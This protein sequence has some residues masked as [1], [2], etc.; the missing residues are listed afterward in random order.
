VGGN[1]LDSYASRSPGDVDLT[2]GDEQAFMRRIQLCGGMMRRRQLVLPGQGY[3]DVVDR[4]A[5]ASLMAEWIPRR[6]ARSRQPST[7]AS[8]LV[9]E[10]SKD[11]LSA[12]QAEV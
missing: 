5:D 4:V 12:T 2:V 10:E 8:A 1:G 11:D 9:A 7:A 6:G 3:L